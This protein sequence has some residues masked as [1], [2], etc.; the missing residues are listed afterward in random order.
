MFSSP[1]L[2][3]QIDG[4]ETKSLLILCA[5]RKKV[6]CLPKWKRLGSFAI[7]LTIRST[8]ITAFLVGK[9]TMMKS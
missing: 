7:P 8:N 9:V 3:S 6:I 5:S 4:F 1:Q 2:T